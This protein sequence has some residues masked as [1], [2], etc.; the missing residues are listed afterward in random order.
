MPRLKDVTGQ[1]FGNLVVIERNGSNSDKK[2]VW[3]C[4]CDCGRTANKT[5]KYL[6]KGKEL[7]CGDEHPIKKCTQCGI[8]KNKNTDYHTTTQNGKKGI[9]A[10]CKECKAN[11]YQENRSKIIT[12]YNE[13]MKDDIWREKRRKIGYKSWQKNKHKELAQKRIYEKR[14][15]IIDK[16]RKRHLVRK[17]TDIQYVIR[18]RLRGRIRDAVKRT[19]GNGYKYKSSIV[20]LGCDMIFFKS[21]I[22]SKFEYGMNWERMTHI[23]IDHIKPCSQFDLTKLEEQKICFHYTNL[24]PLW[25]VDNLIKGHKY[26][27]S[28]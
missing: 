21:Y 17:E 23:H 1:R 12:E 3:L 2:A 20:L 6:R 10:V 8:E 13:R 24:Q 28:K 9:Q 14:P 25:G 15:E 5:G 4:L 26:Q 22:E 16:R 19:L 11:F 7:Y 27:L 18:R